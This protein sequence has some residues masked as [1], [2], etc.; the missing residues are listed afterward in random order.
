M[1]QFLQ[2][3]SD[4]TAWANYLPPAAPAAA[5]TTAGAA[6]PAAPAQPGPVAW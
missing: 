4:T 5:P 3:G 2:T 1:L 6:E